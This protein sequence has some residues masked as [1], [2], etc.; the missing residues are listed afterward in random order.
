MT[1][2]RVVKHL[3]VIEDIAPGFFAVGVDASPNALPLEQ[4]E[5]ALRHVA[6]FGRGDFFGSLAFLD[7]S[8]HD[9]DAV[10]LTDTDV[11]ALSREQFYTISDEHKKLA[12]NLVIALARA[13][14][15]RLRHAES[16]LILLREY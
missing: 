15:L 14:A 1:A 3:D 8:P 16:E 10:A 6:S 12:V 2:L 11:F 4:L 13:L 9:N 7:N 5:E